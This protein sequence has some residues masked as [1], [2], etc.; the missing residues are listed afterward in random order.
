MH[1]DERREQPTRGLPQPRSS[2]P[3]PSQPPGRRRRTPAGPRRRR[4]RR[5]PARATEHQPTDLVAVAHDGVQ[6]Y[7]Y[8]GELQGPPSDLWEGHL[9][10][11]QYTCDRGYGIPIYEADGVTRIGTFELGG[12]GGGG[13]GSSFDGS[14]H[15]QTADAHGTIIDHQEVGVRADHHLPDG[16]QRRHDDEH[17]RGGPEPDAAPQGGA[18][19]H[20]ASDHALVPRHGAEAPR[21][22]L[23][24]PEGARLARR[25]DV[26]RR[27]GGR[28]P[29][30]RRSL[31]AHVPQMRRPARRRVRAGVRQGQV[32]GRVDRRP[33][34]QL[35]RRQ[36][37]PT[38]CS[39][40]GRTT[41]SRG[42]RATTRFDTSMFRLQG[43]TQL[44]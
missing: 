19:G 21:A 36:L 7:C 3:R 16:A 38:S 11:M 35:H 28:R 37:D 43:R 27:A 1:A 42:G 20:L 40:A 12:P 32:Q 24:A 25:Q 33:A 44:H 13:G 41:S 9:R 31:D 4:P 15:E 18:P 29:R 22:H 10:I 5:A 17:G 6:G 39:T 14:R 34:R 2:R 23:E 8:W 30:R 26:P